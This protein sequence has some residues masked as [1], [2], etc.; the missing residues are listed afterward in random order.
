MSAIPQSRVPSDAA[1]HDAAMADA[2]AVETKEIFDGAGVLSS[3]VA[4]NGDAS[5]HFLQVFD[6]GTGDTPV[7]TEVPLVPGFFIPA[8]ESLAV[9]FDVPCA[10]GC[11]LVLS[12]TAGVMTGAGANLHVYARFRQ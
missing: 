3:F 2:T 12:S 1:T 10:N 4:T 7:D 5:G 8:G 11:I 9:Q 6:N